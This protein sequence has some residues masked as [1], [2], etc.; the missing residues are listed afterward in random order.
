MTGVLYKCVL[1]CI[2]V[3]MCVYVDVQFSFV[4]PIKNGK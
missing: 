3:L 1:V 4:K 2:Y